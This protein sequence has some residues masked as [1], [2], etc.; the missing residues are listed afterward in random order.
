MGMVSPCNK[1]SLNSLFQWTIPTDVPGVLSLD[2][3]WLSV[4]RKAGWVINNVVVKGR[5]ESW[6]LTVYV[7]T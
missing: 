1:L 6:V 4:T 7:Q 3:L 5:E 2:S